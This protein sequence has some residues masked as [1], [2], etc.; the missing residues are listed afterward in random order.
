VPPGSSHGRPCGSTRAIDIELWFSSG[1][2]EF[3]VNLRNPDFLIVAGPTGRVARTSAAALFR[4]DVSE[5]AKETPLRSPE[6][7]L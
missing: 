2:R 4:I 7:A 1:R 6:A 3:P 5:W